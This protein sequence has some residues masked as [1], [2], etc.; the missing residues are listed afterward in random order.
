MPACGSR[1]SHLIAG[2]ICFLALQDNWS[3]SHSCILSPSV[4]LFSFFVTEPSF[5]AGLIALVTGHQPMLSSWAPLP[6]LPS[7]YL[8]TAMCSNLAIVSGSGVCYFWLWPTEISLSRSP[9]S[10]P[11]YS[12]MQTN[13]NT[14]ED[15]G[16]RWQRPKMKETWVPQSLGKN[17]YRLRTSFWTFYEWEINYIMACLYH[18]MFEPLIIWGFQ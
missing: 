8:H 17:P 18:I 7:C 1:A 5:L 9:C 11:F 12:L 6:S 14:L 15:E 13:K 2:S 16:R 10:F 4:G 3:C